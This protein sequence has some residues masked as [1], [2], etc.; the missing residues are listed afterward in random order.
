MNGVDRA[1]DANQ[2]FEIARQAVGRIRVTALR[3]GEDILAMEDVGVRHGRGRIVDV[4]TGGGRR[5]VAARQRQH[6]ERPANLN[7][8]AVVQRPLAR[9][10]A[11]DEAGICRIEI[12]NGDLVGRAGDHAVTRRYG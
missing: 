2:G 10:Q 12:A 6:E 3:R 8:I 4:D 5:F 11:I 7:L 9:R 1:A